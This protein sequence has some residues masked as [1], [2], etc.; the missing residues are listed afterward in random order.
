MTYPVWMRHS[1][2]LTLLAVT[3]SYA[4]PASADRTLAQDTMSTSTPVAVSCGFCAM[5]AFGVVFAD[6]GTGGLQPSDFPLTLNSISLALGAAYVSGVGSA[7]TCH[8]IAAGGDTLVHVEIWAGT[9]VPE[10]AD[11]H[12]MPV[13]GSPWPGEDLV[14]TLDDVPVTMSTPTTDGASDFNLM[15][16]PLAL[17][18][19]TTPAPMVDATHTYL[20]AVVVLGATGMSSTCTPDTNAPTGFP[21]RDDDAVVQSHRSFI[22]ATG[23]GWLWNEAV[24]VHGDWGIRLGVLSGPPGDAGP[25]DAA[26]VADAGADAG[27]TA[28]DAATGTDAAMIAAG[29]SRSCGCRAGARSSS[30]ASAALLAL[31][32]L[33]LY[34]RKVTRPKRAGTWKSPS[35][36]ADQPA[37]H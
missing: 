22:Y 13:A 7:A 35:S 36:G 1:I 19:A 23:A 3:L 20:R 14:F 32:A 28:M 18:D 24:G 17:G 25:I 37:P 26:V 33:A 29:G 34:S 4:S 6:I 11:I 9:T 30:P 27:A 16:N 5:E 2:A 31:L 8:G 21:L 10:T 15:L 12:A